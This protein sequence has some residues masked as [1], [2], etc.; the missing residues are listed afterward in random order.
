MPPTTEAACLLDSGRAYPRRL[1]LRDAG[2]AI[3]FVGLRPTG[4]SIYHDDA[5][6]F[7]FDLDGRWQRAFARD[8]HAIRDLDGSTRIVE[9]PREDGTLTLRRTTLPYAEAA[10][11][12][13][14]VRDAAIDLMTGLGS[15]HLT[16]LA[17]PDG[18]ESIATADLLDLLERVVSWDDAAWFAQRER[19]A[20]TYGPWPFLPPSLPNAILFQKTLGDAGG[21]AFGGGRP[22]AHAVRTPAEFR[23]H[24]REVSTL[25]GR[26][27][28]QVNATVIG[29]ADVA[30]LPADEVLDALTTAGTALTGASKQ[31][32]HFLLSGN[33]S[34]LPDRSTW[35]RFAAA[36]L[37]GITLQI[38]PQL[39]SAGLI[40]DL[41]AGGIAVGL[42]V[43]VA[44]SALGASISDWARSFESLPLR[45]GD[46]ITVVDRRLIAGDDAESPDPD[47]TSPWVAELKRV[48]CPDGPSKGPRVISYNQARHQ[49]A[50]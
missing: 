41:R 49:D 26:R 16:P 7:H 40:D 25:I 31:S 1:G 34:G 11:W 23:D 44:P 15:G 14:L 9:R 4:F 3:V 36:G 32:L 17:P 2:G 8:T 48:V 20:A 21:R 35:A 33:G 13:S 27:I 19:Y 39:P 47:G 28:T 10:E 6:I 24:V 37:T 22:A 12:D 38:D 30:R 50:R 42:L 45:S 29:G 43:A 46:L 18:V 5:P